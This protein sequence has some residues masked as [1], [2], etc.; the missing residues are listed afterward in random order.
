MK[1]SQKRQTGPGPIFVSLAILFALAAGSAIFFGPDPQSA[2]GK[3]VLAIAAAVAMFG[4]V[5]ILGFGRRDLAVRRRRGYIPG[6]GVLI[7][8]NGSVATAWLVGLV[9]LFVVSYEISRLFK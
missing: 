2:R 3:L 7:S 6:P 4:S 9:A 1:D 5:V 8:L